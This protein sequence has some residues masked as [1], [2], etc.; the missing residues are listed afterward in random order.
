MN[1][2]QTKQADPFDAKL[3]KNAERYKNKAYHEGLAIAE[4]LVSQFPRKPQA[5]DQKGMFQRALGDHLAA[6]QSFEKARDLDPKS[7]DFHDHLAIALR[8]LGKREAAVESYEKA[9]AIDTNRAITWG[10][11]GNVLRDLKRDQEALDAYEKAVELTPKAANM[12]VM[13]AQALIGMDKPEDGLKQALEAIKLDPDNASAH[14]EIGC[15]HLQLGQYDDAIVALNRSIELNPNVHGVHHNLATVYQQTGVLDKATE[16]YREALKINPSFGPAQRQ[17][18]SITKFEAGDAKL[19]ELEAMAK[20][21]GLEESQ[22][23]DVYFTLAKAYDD[24]KEFD[25]A[26]PYLQN[27]NQIVRKDIEYDSKTNANFVNRIIDTYSTEFFES[28]QGQGASSHVPVFIVGMPRSGTTLTE[29]I[30]SSHPEVFGAGELMKMSE[31]TSQMQKDFGLKG[32]YPECAGEASEG[33]LLSFAGNYLD[34][35]R[36]FDGKAH[37]VTDKMPFNYRML[38]LISVIFPNAKIVHCRRH[39]YDIIIS[40][41]FARFKEQLAFSYNLLEAARYVRDYERL[42]DHWRQTLPIP[43]Y[44]TRYDELVTDQEQKSREIIEFCGLQWDDAC[45]QFHENKRPVLTA[46]NWQVRQPMYSSSVERWRNYEKFLA[47]LQTV[48]GPPEVIYP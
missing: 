36:E 29:Q 47:P 32:R 31:L 9:L 45:L 17:L 15:A 27:A 23:A 6:K 11:M 3:Q 33:N 2:A 18:S 12:R 5:W 44:E 38:G 46:S 7:A 8:A 48:L 30:I 14:S 43:I 34:H 37:R 42:M 26:F 41:Y 10:N 21:V 19:D 13:Y 28:H 39:P 4:T 1:Q 16:C 25:K 40:C 35:L 22:R 24:T 20:S